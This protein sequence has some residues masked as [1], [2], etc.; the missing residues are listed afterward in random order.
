MEYNVNNSSVDSGIDMQTV[1]QYITRIVKKWWVILLSALIFAGLGFGIAKLNYQAMYS[2]TM[3]FAVDNRSENTVSGGT[4]SSDISAGISL[5]RNYEI[6]MTETNSLMDLVAKNSGYDING[7][8]VKKMLSSNLVEDTAIIS[9]TVTSSNPDVSYAVAQ[10]YVNHYSEITD[11]AYQSTRAIVYDEP[12]KPVNPNPDNST[13]LYTLLGFLIGAAIVIFAVCA[14]ILIKDTIKD[15]DGITKKLESKVLGSV[16]HIKKNDKK[17]AKSSLLITDKKTGFMFIES[18]KLI[19]TKIENIA[20]RQNYKTFVFTSASENEG[21]TTVATNTALALAKNGKSVLLID[22]DL[23]KPSVYKALGVSGTNETGLAGVIRGEKSLS[24]SIKYFEKFNLFLLISGQPVADSAEILSD[25]AMEDTLEAVKNEFDYII[26][27]T[28]PG[29]LVADA[30][31]IAQHADACVMIVR[32][33]L[34][35]FRRIKRTME[36]ITGSGA[37]LVGCIFNDAE[38]GVAAKFIK[39]NKKRRKSSGY[40]YGYD[41]GYGYGYGYGESADKNNKK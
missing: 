9:L 39:T 17:N 5:A 21:K 10:S 36:D 23:R 24:D 3:R 41:Y 32:R 6:I 18:Y 1:M 37:E 20:K 30:S 4:S 26:I 19:R 31:I 28:P 38:V 29:G 35:P 22:A 2:C 11:T 33:D 12:V 27:D 40:G 13:V 16:I 8:D 34:A 14:E 15:P 25:D 7:A